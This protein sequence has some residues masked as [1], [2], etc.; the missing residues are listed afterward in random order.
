MDD[1]ASWKDWRPEH[2][3]RF[4]P[5]ENR[6]FRWHVRRAIG[7]RVPLRVLEVGFG[8]GAF[9]GWLRAQGHQAHGVETNTR[10]CEVARAHGFPAFESLE[11]LP[12]AECFD[13]IAAFDVAEHIPR[14]ALPGWMKALRERCKDGGCLL[15]R[16]PNGD[17]PFGLPNQHGDLTH[18]T[19][20][21]SSLLRQVA[22][23][24]GWRIVCTGDAPWWADQHYSRSFHGA[25]RAL[26]R[27]LFERFVCYMYFN[28]RLD[29][30]PNMVT[31]LTPAEHE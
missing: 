17:S 16:C 27:R 11:Q 13:L 14:D 10:L 28:T 9:L 31:V 23:M 30:R 29:L 25:T 6:Y 1:Y 24:S 22:Q 8:N 2:F 12:A 21:G 15:L 18:V 20:I 26:L 5:R 4:T 7:D 3:G 19:A